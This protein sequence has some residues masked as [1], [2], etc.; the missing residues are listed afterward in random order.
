V[1]PESARYP[2]SHWVSFVCGTPLRYTDP[3][4]HY[5]CEED[6]CLGQKIYSSHK[7]DTNRDG[8][9][10]KGEAITYFVMNLQ[11]PVNELTVTTRFGAGCTMA[12]CSGHHPGVD[13]VGDHSITATSNGI[14]V[15]VD[16]NPEGDFGMKVV[17]QT[18]VFG[19]R[20]YSI[21]AHL[22]A[23]AVK[24][25]VEISAGASIG[26]MGSTPVNSDNWIHLHYEVRTEANVNLDTDG[27][28]LSLPTSATSYWAD[29]LDDLLLNWIDLGPRFGYST[30]YPA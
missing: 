15:D 1:S 20:F 13:F 25:G 28:Y 23:I 8:N 2:V 11:D 9:I 17:V 4:G 27:T 22:S 29:S 12:G 5:I 7:A 21:Y 10:S 24:P 3:T 19:Y 26:T 18:D 16:S 30:N 14:V 6:N